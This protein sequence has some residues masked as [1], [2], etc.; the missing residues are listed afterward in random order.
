MIVALF[1]TGGGD[2]YCTRY[3]EIESVTDT[4]DISGEVLATLTEGDTGNIGNE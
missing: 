4:G 3:F 1:H 2:I